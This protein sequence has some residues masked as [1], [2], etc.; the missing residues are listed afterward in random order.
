MVDVDIEAVIVE[1]VR[2]RMAEL[3]CRIYYD[4]SAQIVGIPEWA[5][6]SL[7]EAMALSIALT[8]ISMKAR[9]N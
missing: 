5:I 3:E 6:Q 4:N 1:D 7:R 2:R 8:E 9:W